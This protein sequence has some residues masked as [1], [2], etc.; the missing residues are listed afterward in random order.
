MF[1]KLAFAAWLALI[2]VTVNQGFPWLLEHSMQLITGC[3]DHLLICPE[4]RR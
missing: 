2:L 3:P 1:R 4:Q